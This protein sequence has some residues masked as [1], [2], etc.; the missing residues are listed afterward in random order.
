MARVLVECPMVKKVFVVTLTVKARCWL[1]ANRPKGDVKDRDHSPTDLA[2][3]VGVHDAMNEADKLPLRYKRCLARDHQVEEGAVPVRGINRLW[4]MPRDDVISEAPDRIQIPARREEL[5]GAD[6][7]VARRD[8]GQYR[9]GQ[10]RPA[11]I[12]DLP[13]FLPPRKSQNIRDWPAQRCVRCYPQA[14]EDDAERAVRAGLEL[15]AAVSGLKHTHRYTL[16]SA[17]RQ[18]GGCRRS[19]RLGRFSGAGHRRRDAKSCCAL[20]GL[21]YNFRA[22]RLLNYA[23]AKNR[24]VNP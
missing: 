19:D 24:V 7:D 6:T 15:V 16:V 21:R 14:Y 18:V 10:R 13:A 9:A 4:V 11:P 20:A 23:L 5:Q 2:H 1:A 17:L 8:A 22:R 12:I 3:V